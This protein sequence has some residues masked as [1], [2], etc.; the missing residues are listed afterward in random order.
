MFG[1]VDDASFELQ[2]ASLNKNGSK[3]EAE[4]RATFATIERGRGSVNAIPTELRKIIAEE[5]ISGTPAKELSK[6]FEISESSIS[7]YKNDATSTSSYNQPN[8]E[9]A[10]S[11]DVVRQT[12]LDG[13]RGKI[14]IALE[15]ITDEKLRDAKVRDT[16]SVA[17]DM[18]AIIRNLE[19]QTDKGQ[20]GLNQ[21]FIFYAP[22]SKKESD[23]EVVEMRD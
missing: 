12:I 9:L 18:S 2:L 4:P 14:L 23:F 5:A 7:A 11:N 15:N 6:L 21:Q 16:A 10:K 19:P 3:N 22:K 13:A 8:G 20:N 17:K 1:I